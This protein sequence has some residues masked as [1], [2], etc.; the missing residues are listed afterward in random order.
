MFGVKRNYPDAVRMGEKLLINSGDKMPRDLHH[1]V[2]NYMLKHSDSYYSKESMA[3]SGPLD[4]A[5]LYGS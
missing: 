1:S 3:R 5:A 2:K 4:S